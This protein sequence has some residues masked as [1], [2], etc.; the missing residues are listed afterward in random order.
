MY[1]IVFDNE[2][3]QKQAGHDE[4]LV[5]NCDHHNQ[6]IMVD[7]TQ[8]A[9]M[10]QETVLHEFLH[11]CFFTSGLT[12]RLSAFMET[13]LEEDIIAALSPLLYDS[14]IRNKEFFREFFK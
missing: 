12:S 1:T 11:A 7:H 2:Q 10:V 14:F 9:Q 8:S 5:G 4:E 3:L 6:R 13:N